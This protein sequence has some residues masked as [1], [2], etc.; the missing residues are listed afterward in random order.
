MYIW[1]NGEVT[2]SVHHATLEAFHA[3]LAAGEP[4]DA[5][6]ENLPSGLD[7]GDYADYP[8]PDQPA[9]EEPEAGEPEGD[10]LPK[11]NASRDDWAAYALNHGMTAEDLAPADREQLGRDE[12]RDH[13]NEE[14]T[15]GD[16]AVQP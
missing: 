9:D 3:A 4:L 16:D 7:A 15:D 11:G 6:A 2:G 8:I 10:G 14:V 12:I 5:F 13:F 1:P